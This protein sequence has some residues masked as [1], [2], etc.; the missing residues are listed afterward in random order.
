MYELVTNDDLSAR[1]ASIRINS[2]TTVL[3]R[4]GVPHDVFAHYW[5]DVH[6]PLCA[7]IP[8]LAWYVQNHFSREQDSHLWPLAGDVAPF[9]DYVLDGGVEI[10][11]ASEKDQKVFDEACHLLFA[12][13]QNVFQETIA[14]A[15]P[16]GSR[17][18]VDRFVDPTPNGA[19][20]FDRLHVHFGA[21]GA[22]VS[23]FR[24][25]LSDF[26][27]T[28]TALD[29]VLKLRLHLPEVY[30]NAKPAPPAPNVGHLV[31]PARTHLAVMELV[32]TSPLA[33]CAAFESATFKATVGGQVKHLGFATAFPVSGV[34]TYIRDKELT[35]AGLRGSRAAELT[36]RLGADNQLRADVRHL[37]QH[38]SP[39]PA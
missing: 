18:F 16:Q 8:G 37:L 14:Y 20:S 31:P 35:T 1:D 11:F 38:G 13:E 21:R 15:L 2:Y 9:P 24:D 39:A 29:G 7:R 34:Y 12:D 6:G 33:R 26:A 19:D 23:A 17:T 25:F 32:F 30:D 22:D 4:T 3:R 28:I 10:G 36:A 5:R 27:A